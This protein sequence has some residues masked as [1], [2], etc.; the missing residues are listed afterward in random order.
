MHSPV[1]VLSPLFYAEAQL[2]PGAQLELDD[3]HHDRAIYVTAGT[4]EMQQQSFEAA[5]MLVFRPGCP[6][7]VRAT[8]NARLMLLGG[9]PLDGLRYVWWNFVSSDPERMQRAAD[10]WQLG[11]FARV[12]GDDEFIPLPDTRPPRAEATAA[13]R[14]TDYP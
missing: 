9:A 6:V 1:P 5:N 7:R 10:D 12:P 13:P 2:Q 8:T 4:V 11:R 3:E 14:P